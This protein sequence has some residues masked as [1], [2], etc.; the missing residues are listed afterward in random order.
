ML[1]PKLFK[2]D[3]KGRARFWQIE[4]DE[5]GMFRSLSGLVEGNKVKTDEWTLVEIKNKGR[6]N[7]TTLVGQAKAEIASLYQKK[8]DNHYVDDISKIH[9]ERAYFEVML[10]ESYDDYGKN[11]DWKAGVYVQPKLDGIRGP[12]K[13]SGTLS[14]KGTFFPTV[15]FLSQ[16]VLAPLFKVCPNVVLDGELYNHKFRD[17]FNEISSIIKREKAKPEDMAKARELVQLYVYDAYFPDEPD[18]KFIDRYNKI[19][20]LIEKHVHLFNPDAIVIVPTFLVHSPEE[21]DALYDQFIDEEFEGQMLRVNTEYFFKRVQTLLK[22]KDFIDGEFRLVDI[23]P[24]KGNWSG[25]AKK[26]RAL[27]PDGR[28]FGAGCKG[29]KEFLRDILSNKEEY[30]WA[31]ITYFKPTPDGIPRFPRVKTFFKGERN[32]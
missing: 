18:M 4:D 28:E 16:E 6:A 19:K 9:E 8:R 24:G 3:S 26:V 27:L 12:T 11:L 7:E 25:V 30:T 2:K 15:Q 20:D 21:A 23:L 1:H 31:T 29:K 10:A 5:T 32:D 22:R 13:A 14:R 17:D